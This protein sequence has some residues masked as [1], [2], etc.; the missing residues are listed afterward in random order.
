[1]TTVTAAAIT[2]NVT[3]TVAT[4]A[5]TVT[6]VTPGSS[7]RSQQ[8]R[9]PELGEIILNAITLPH[10]GKFS[11]YAPAGAEN[12]CARGPRRR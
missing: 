5:A 12:I 4:A 7:V 1:M 3:T 9:V 10:L 8:P 6:V 2:S 11:V